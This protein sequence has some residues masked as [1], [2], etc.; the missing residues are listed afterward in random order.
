MN[1]WLLA[2]CLNRLR[3]C[4]SRFITALTRIYEYTLSWIK[5]I[6]YTHSPYFLMVRF[7]CMLLSVAKLLKLSALKFISLSHFTNVCY[8]FR[9]THSP[10]CDCPNSIWL[11]VHIIQFFITYPFPSAYYFLSLWGQ[12]VSRISND[13]KMLDSKTILGRKVKKFDFEL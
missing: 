8:V 11:T 13:I 5:W 3:H 7:K 6:L 1:L 10:C 4:V 12:I 2:K 9:Q